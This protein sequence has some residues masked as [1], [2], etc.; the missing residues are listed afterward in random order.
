MTLISEKIFD[1]DSLLSRVLGD[2]E[3][4]REVIQVFLGDV[5]KKITAIKQ[6]LDKRD[7]TLVRDQAHAI[8]GAAM[9]ASA[10]AL[11]EAAYQMEQAGEA[12]DIDT[13]DTLMP[14]IEEQFEILKN[15]LIESGLT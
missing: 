1:K 5:P 8:K 9:N 3:L 15:T 6:A 13:A 2:E 7:I 11:K 14:Q 10:S 4:A 12:A